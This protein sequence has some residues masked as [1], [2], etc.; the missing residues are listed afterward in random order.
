[1]PDAYSIEQAQTTCD[2]ANLVLRD[3]D[4]QDAE[5][6]RIVVYLSK[7]SMEIALKAFLARAGMPA[8][9]IADMRHDLK[10]LLLAV[11]RC[12][13]QLEVGGQQRWASASRVR[14]RV[15]PDAPGAPDLTLGWV[16]E[17]ES[18]GASR[19]PNEIRYADAST[20]KDVPVPALVAAAQALIDWVNN[21]GSTARLAR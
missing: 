17:A 11:G 1:M 20:L 5:V 15:V 13:V 12:D 21:E 10:K 4:P 3:A 2:A 19:F 14:A 18:H 7:M 6:L 16:L 9:E 8:R